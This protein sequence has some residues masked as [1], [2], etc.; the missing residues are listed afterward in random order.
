MLPLKDATIIG[1]KTSMQ[2]LHVDEIP[3]LSNPLFVLAFEG[4]ND[5]A[6]SATIAA[7]Y[8]VNH[9]NGKRFA[10]FQ[11]DDFFQFSDQRP[12]VRL[13][14]EGN[15]LIS[16]P[17]NE[18]YCCKH[19]E[20]PR[21][22]I[23]GIGV[24]PQLRWKLF[25]QDVFELIQAC[26]ARLTVTMGAL[27]AGDSHKNP[28]EMV[29][30]A[31]DRGLEEKTGVKATKYEGPTGIVGVIHTQLQDEHMP[32]VSLW[33]NIPHYIS[34]LPNPKGAYA[35]LVGLSAVAEISLDLGEMERSAEQFD[36]QI[37]EAISQDPKITQ[38][39]SQAKMD[40]DDEEDFEGNENIGRE[41]PKNLPTGEDL[42]DEIESYLR[43][44]RRDNSS[45]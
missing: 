34:S 31:T 6:Q 29:C 44:R 11:S 40:E 21:D 38:Y 17:T 41:E 12:Q 43:R 36:A 26:G 33:A 42:A 2:H 8:L 13:D 25:S 18:F 23:V 22:L 28:I 32:A 14:K 27:L 45:E 16:W 24:E 7:R 19:P 15:R 4:W 10:W 30:L 9:F 39:L 1:A 20:L 3:E 5:A 35:L 37:E